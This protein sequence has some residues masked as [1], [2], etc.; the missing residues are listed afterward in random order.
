MVLFGGEYQKI[1]RKQEKEIKALIFTKKGLK[2][3]IK[4]A[5]SRGTT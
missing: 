1:L 5:G 4:W 3:P 2:C